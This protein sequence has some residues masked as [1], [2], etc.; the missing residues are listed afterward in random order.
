MQ[1][2]TWVMSPPLVFLAAQTACFPSRIASRTQSVTSFRAP[3]CR[4]MLDLRQCRPLS[5]FLRRRDRINVSVDCEPANA[6]HLVNRLIL[7]D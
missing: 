6:F 2:S 4:S 5:K 3:F 1:P 7:E